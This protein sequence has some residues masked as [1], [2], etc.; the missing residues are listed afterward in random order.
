MYVGVDIKPQY[1]GILTRNVLAYLTGEVVDP[2]RRAADCKTESG[3]NIRQSIFLKGD[4]VPDWWEGDRASC[5]ASAECGHC[6]RTLSFRRRAIS[7]AFVIK[8]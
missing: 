3:Q 1:H 2:E 4:A 7:P 6:Y 5:N 8:E